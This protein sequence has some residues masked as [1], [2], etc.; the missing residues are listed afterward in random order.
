MLR[1]SISFG[2]LCRRLLAALFE[3]RDV[4]VLN[5]MSDAEPERRGLAQAAVSWSVRCA[6]CGSTSRGL[7]WFDGAEARQRSRE[8]PRDTEHRWRA[9]V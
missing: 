7:A 6:L 3:F 9:R 8:P 5:K 1:C 2:R 4:I